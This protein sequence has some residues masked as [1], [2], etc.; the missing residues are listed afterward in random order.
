MKEKGNIGINILIVILVVLIIT[1]G[2]LLFI[3]IM[4]G[5]TVLTNNNLEENQKEENAIIEEEPKEPEKQVQI[6]T[7]TDRP[8]AVMIDNVGD[9]IPQAGLNDAY[10]VYE[11]IAEGGLTRYMALFKGVDLEKIGPVRSSR[12]YYLD[13][14]MENDAI[15]VHYG[16]SP[17]AESDISR[18]NINNINGITAP[19][20]TFW[21]AKDKSSPHNAVTSTEKIKNQAEKYGYRMESDSRSVLNYVTDEV[22][23]D[24]EDAIIATDIL[25]PYPSCKSRFKYNEETAR[26]ERYT[27][28]TLLKDWDTKEVVSTKNIIITFAGNSTL[29]DGEGK[30]RQDLDNV[31][32]LKGYYITNG[33][34][35]EIVC[36]KNSRNSKTVYKDLE[37]NVINVNDGNTFIEICPLNTN[38]TF[39]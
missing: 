12:H 11:I 4:E 21:R 36:S 17:Q 29:N 3:K 28:G 27:N 5:Q 19:S 30:G 39:E 13:Y 6:F 22:T 8:I 34:A 37:G 14:A 38:V 16:W 7:G 32:D 26:Y 25:I 18:Y 1:A 23:L 2:V 33:K 31:G 24:T 20:T 35:I 10:I 9:A 15:Y